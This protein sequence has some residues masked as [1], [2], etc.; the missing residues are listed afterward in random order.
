MEE[1]KKNHSLPDIQ[2]A[3]IR[4]GGEVPV[5]EFFGIDKG[6]FEEMIISKLVEKYS[7]NDII[8]EEKMEFK[9]E[10]E[11]ASLHIFQDLYNEF[12]DRQFAFA[13]W[14][15]VDAIIKMFAVN[16]VKYKND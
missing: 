7:N 4:E 3:G 13:M 6:E 1:A 8:D 5:F 16:G 11:T 9:P 2:I 12:T 10:V 15:Y 14:N